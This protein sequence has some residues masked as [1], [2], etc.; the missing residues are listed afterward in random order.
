M[1]AAI[2]AVNRF[3]T[4]NILNG[5]V[6]VVDQKATFAVF[7][8]FRHAAPIK[9][10]HGCS[11]GHGFDNG[12]A[13]RLIKLYWVQQRA[14]FAQQTVAL[15][16]S[17]AADINHLVEVYVRG[18]VMVIVSMILNN[19]RQYQLFTAGSGDFQGFAGPLVLVNAPEKK[20]VIVRGRLKIKLLDIDAVMDGF[21][22]V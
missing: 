1:A 2:G 15:S 3:N 22:I 4:G 21:D 14:G 6:H 17:D 19:T 5:L 10:D 7:D 11:T 12:Q 9:G 13:E 16:G 18:D 20:Q 8:K